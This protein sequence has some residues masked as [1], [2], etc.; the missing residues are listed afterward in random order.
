M[1]LTIPYIIHVILKF[2]LPV[3]SSSVS[4]LHCGLS[5]NLKCRNTCA[6]VLKISNFNFAFL[7]KRLV[8]RPNDMPSAK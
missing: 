3:W 4:S 7:I 1:N 5:V 8:F 2:I 6:P